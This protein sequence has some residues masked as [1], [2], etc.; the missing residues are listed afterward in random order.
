[1]IDDPRFYLAAVPAVVLFGLAKG[2]FAGLVIIGMSL[3]VQ[4]ISPL[5]AAA[6]ML[7]ILMVQD[8]VSLWVYR[9]HIDRPALTILLPGAAA[10]VVLGGF[11]AAVVSDALVRALI[12]LVAIVFAGNHLLGLG[13]RLAGSALTAGRAAG[14]FWGALSGFTSVIS[15]AGGPPYQIWMLSRKLP[16][17]FLVGTTTW[18]FA[19]VNAMKA[20]F[21]A[22]LGL[23]DATSLTTSAALAPL[24]VVA[25]M[26]GVWLVRRTPVDRFYG[27]IHGLMLL[28]GLKLLYDG[29]KAGV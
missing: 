12:G 8:V 17:D 18:F 28:V 26:L 27:I 2:G 15:H 25:T 21:F 7:P 20:P 6:I 19:I 24:A 3:V 5:K 23:F 9:R 1:M 13:S 14:A 10:G 4:T 29:L 16:R 22:G 11:T